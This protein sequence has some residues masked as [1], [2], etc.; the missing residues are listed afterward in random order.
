MQK[1]SDLSVIVVLY[2]ILLEKSESF[3]S[4]RRSVMSLSHSLDVLVFDHSET[5]HTPNNTYKNLVIEYYHDANNPGLSNAYNKG[6]AISKTKNK[7]WIL[8]L[9]Q[10]TT[11]SRDAISKYLIYIHKY[12]QCALFV[13]QLYSGKQLVSP[14]KLGRGKGKYLK[15]ITYGMHDLNNIIPINSGSLIRL[16]EFEKCGGYDEKFKLDF[17]DFS[18]FDRFKK[19][20]KMFYVLPLKFQHDFSGI[21]KTN[22]QTS[23][24]RFHI[25]SKA[26]FL[27]HSAYDS[28]FNPVIRVIFRALK[29]TATF[30]SLKFIDVA[31]KMLFNR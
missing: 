25:Y 29:L 23:L 22:L 27:Y 1:V 13:P 14:F 9:D 15:K 30:K 17:S 28:S 24:S 10:D 12:P 2:N 16:L 18:F 21:N 7:K 4:L 26:V 6:Y 11:L 20:T 19:S 31:F 5:A 8:L 3:Q